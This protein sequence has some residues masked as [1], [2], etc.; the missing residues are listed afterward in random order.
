MDK[1]RKTIFLVDDDLTNLT[2]GKKALVDLYNVFTL[3]SGA[4]MME[5]LENIT[6]DL[7][8]LDVNMP[9]MNGYEVISKLKE[10]E[11]TASIPVIFLTARREE[12]SELQGFNL[13]AIDY[14]M[15]PFSISILL[16]R[17]E[18]HLQSEEEKVKLQEQ[19]KELLHSKKTLQK[20]VE[21]KQKT[22]IALKNAFI[23]TFKEVK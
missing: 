10:K 16:K 5:L 9:E 12:E 15:K 11:T 7:I 18:V 1:K 23:D 13:G 8:L 22:A 3:S 17:I 21:E 2:I 6:P 19:K 4:L 14:I 20:K